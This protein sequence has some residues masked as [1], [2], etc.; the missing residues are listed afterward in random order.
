MQV[1]KRVG[2][3]PALRWVSFLLLVVVAMGWAA[4]TVLA[5]SR[6]MK[7]ADTSAQ[8]FSTSATGTRIKV[9]VSIDQV[10]GETLK[11]TVL[12]RVSDAVYRRP[13]A[14]AAAISA[15][16]SPE[17][18]VAMGKARDIVAGAIVQLAGTVDKDR[19]LRTSQLVILTG[20]VRL[21]DDSQ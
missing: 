20:Y 12:E 1:L 3:S 14:G 21:A 8:A 15:I 6:H 7:P 9:V 18:S 5:H 2:I 13:H 4:R 16:L 19:T 10:V 17:T 11:V